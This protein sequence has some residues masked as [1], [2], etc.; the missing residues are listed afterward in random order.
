MKKWVPILFLLVRIYDTCGQE[1]SE[2]YYRENPA[3]DP[4]SVP[5]G[6]SMLFYAP[7]GSGASVFDR[8]SA[9]LSASVSYCR[10]GDLRGERHSYYGMPVFA[11]AGRTDYVLLGAV[12]TEQFPYEERPTTASDRLPEVTFG[13]RA[14]LYGLSAAT[15]P[16][17]IYATFGFS[18]R[19]YGF[20]VAGAAAGTAG[21]GWFYSAAFER[22]W[23]HDSYADGVYTDAGSAVL[24]VGKRFGRSGFLSLGVVVA[25][26]LRGLRAWSTEEV[27]GLAGDNMYNPSWGFWNGKRRNPRT[28]YN[29][30][31]LTTAA[32][33]FDAGA[34]GTLTIGAAFLAGSRR[35]S[36]LT[37]RNAANP[38]PDHYTRLPGYF[39][40][41][42]AAR[43]IES[44]WSSGDAR[45]AHIDWERLTETNR[46]SADG[47]VYALASRVER[48]KD[49]Y[50]AASGV[51]RPSG[52]LAVRYGVGI[53]RR[54]SEIFRMADDL[55]G[56]AP[57]RDIDSYLIGDEIWGGL[58]ENDVRTSGRTVGEGDRFGFEYS[59]TET[60]L[61]GYASAGYET[62]RFRMF[63]SAVLSRTFYRRRG[64]YEK[65]TLPGTLSFGPSRRAVFPGWSVGLS[66]GWSLTARSDIS[67]YVSYE[68]AP[69]AVNDAFLLPDYAN[70]LVPAA[71]SARTLRA[72]V[73]GRFDFRTVRLDATVYIIRSEAEGRV[74]RYYDDLFSE[75]SL[76]C[77]SG[78]RRLCC[79]I[80]AGAQVNIT[81]RFSVSAAAAL[82]RYSYVSSPSVDIYSGVNLKPLLTG[83]ESGLRG[84]VCAA[85]PQT[86][87]CAEA[88]FRHPSGWRVSLGWVWLSDRYAEAEPLR[89]TPRILQL[90]AS[91]EAG[92]RFSGQARLP[93]VSFINLYVSKRFY[94]GV[95]DFTVS[96]SAD[97]LLSDGNTVY[98]EREQMRFVRRRSGAAE[99]Y[100]PLPSRRIYSYPL[101][102][103]ASLSYKF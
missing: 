33:S 7:V 96:V 80:E 13:N 81:P 54:R 90:A 28:A 3:D 49:V 83:S 23:G 18:G 38:F 97:N 87:V 86:A 11:A 95:G 21:R 65:E 5:S 20:R 1:L 92:A 71:R 35:L 56:G 67:G 26:S 94:S 17:R 37:W 98:G 57:F 75:Y 29:F 82:N 72:G 24:S 46:Y 16:R 36:G 85:A 19:G 12:R 99:V 44:A 84:Y 78:I 58:Y 62:G 59:M 51:A 9:Y 48:P 61:R 60:H 79:G 34:A 73:G 55:L 22:R 27:F 88:M 64:R 102:L 63:V 42:R 32:Y 45:T 91:P 43:R 39:S 30:T 101:V 77:L 103:R 74:L 100:E 10:R 50:F 31:P 25:P 15:W 52:R 47:A 41:G 76:M 2:T 89:R 68:G 14:A 53:G 40:D 66:A 70:S 6:D 93:D 8:L 4:V 69:P